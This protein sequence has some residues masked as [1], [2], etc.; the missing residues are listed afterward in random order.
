MDKKEFKKI[1]K[2]LE[3]IIKKDANERNLFKKTGNGTF[4]YLIEG[5]NII[6]HIDFVDGINKTLE[7]FSKYYDIPYKPLISKSVSKY[8]I[9]K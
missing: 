4:D 7:I 8:K 9:R 5:D 1:R 3:E 2:E 6:E